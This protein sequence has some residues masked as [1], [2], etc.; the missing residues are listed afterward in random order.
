MCLATLHAITFFVNLSFLVFLLAG[1]FLAATTAI[2]I[3]TA[4]KQFN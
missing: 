4:N 2:T 1:A 3:L